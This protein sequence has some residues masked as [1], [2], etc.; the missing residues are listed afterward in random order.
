MESLLLYR[1]PRRSSPV[2]VASP[3]SR[4]FPLNF[5]GRPSSGVRDRLSTPA[6]EDDVDDRSSLSVLD[7]SSEVLPRMW[8]LSLDVRSLRLDLLRSKCLTVSD[9]ITSSAG[10]T[11]FAEGDSV[12]LV[13]WEVS[14]GVGR[15]F[16]REV[17]AWWRA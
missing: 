16:L 4:Y 5:R 3:V 12:L 13:F 8:S 6:G 14:W 9:V 17:S 10:V 7:E 2:G 11:C 1:F 15:L